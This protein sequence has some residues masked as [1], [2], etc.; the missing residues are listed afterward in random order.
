[1]DNKNKNPDLITLYVKHKEFEMLLKR[2]ENL[3]KQYIDAVYKKKSSKE[4]INKIN[5]E[6]D[7][8]NV[9][10]IDLS[11]QMTDLS[12][13]LK[14]QSS[15]NIEKINSVEKRIEKLM[16]ILQK[17]QR[18]LSRENKEFVDSMGQQDNSVIVEESSNLRYLF[19]F[20]FVFLV[21]AALVHS[22]TSPF[23]T[24][25]EG[26]IFS[27]IIAVVLYQIVIWIL[28]KLK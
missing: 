20:I 7:V 22:L 4:E 1:M 28:H 6:L 11:K 23:E 8:T 5:S 17:E 13:K 19:L 10:L 21:I 2:Y 12:N 14:T 16:P 18:R 15:V 3:N 24:K 25:L 26:V 27:L 9:N